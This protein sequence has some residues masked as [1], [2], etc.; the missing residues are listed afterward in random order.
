MG[1]LESSRPKIRHCREWQWFHH[2]LLDRIFR[3]VQDGWEVRS[4][5]L[6]TRQTRQQSYG[7]MAREQLDPEG[8]IPIIVY[9]RA[10]NF[11]IDGFG[12]TSTIS[13]R[14]P[15]LWVNN[16]VLKVVGSIE[17]LE[18]SP[19]NDNILIMSDASVDESFAT[20]AWIITTEASFK[21]NE[22]I[23]GF[24]TVPGICNDSH[25][26]E[27]FGILGG[28]STWQRYKSLWS[29]QPKQNVTIMCDNQAAL[30]YA[31]NHI[32]Y[33][34][35]SSK[36]PDYDVLGAIRAI[37]KDENFDYKHVKGHQDRVSQNLD[38]LALLNIE[39]DKLANQARENADSSTL[40]SY[41]LQ[42]EQWVLEVEGTKVVKD[43]DNKL[44]EYIRF[45]NIAE[46]WIKSD[47]ISRE[48]IDKVAWEILHQTMKTSTNQTRHWITKRA[49]KDCGTNEVLFKRKQRGDDKCPFCGN[50]ETVLHVYQCQHDEVKNVWGKSIYDMEIALI[51]QQ[52]DPEII[53]QLISGLLQWQKGNVMGNNNGKYINE[54][55]SIGWNGI[56]EGCIGQQWIQAQGSYLSRI[57]VKKS[58]ERWAQL[59]IRRLWKIAW[60]L[61]ENR[62][63]KEHDRDVEREHMALQVAI[64]AEIDKG[65]EG[66]ADS[67]VLFS[68]SELSKARGCNLAYKRA[69]LRNVQA[70]RRS[71]TSGLSSRDMLLMRRTMHRF[72]NIN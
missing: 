42:E 7:N 50:T 12:D 3:K 16:V 5:I 47:R 18:R 23:C 67:H 20:A 71:A 56:L 35:I 55:S 34:Y 40:I 54:Q 51:E 39:V 26:G 1:V 33:R 36:I 58:K 43:I 2:P 60:H 14:L 66:I 38:L 53:R 6:T 61:W 44:R 62:N 64:N 25:R 13:E 45:P 28:I 32:R 65:S 52:T 31:C 22:Y 46:K 41:G 4:R 59:V 11:Y 57:K 9:S 70:R 68:D 10:D 24:G 30:N 63:K 15:E 27:C 19:Q 48:G 69:W 21:R 8:M 17:Q 72:L 29:I 49:A 37:L